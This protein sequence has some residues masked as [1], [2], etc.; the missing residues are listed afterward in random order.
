M[1]SL[2]FALLSL[3]VIPIGNLVTVI[4]VT[5]PLQITDVNIAL[6]IILA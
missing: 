3:S 4:G 1:F 5:T 6:L 2:I